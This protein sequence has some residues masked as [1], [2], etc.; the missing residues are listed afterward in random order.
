[1]A[2]RQRESFV[3]RHGYP[4]F[5]LDAKALLDRDV[6]QRDLQ[7]LVSLVNFGSDP[8][9]YIAPATA[10]LWK[11]MDEIPAALGVDA[12]TFAC[13]FVPAAGCSYTPEVIGPLV[14]WHVWRARLYDWAVSTT[15]GPGKTP[16]NPAL[17]QI[18]DD[19][20]ELLEEMD[21]FVRDRLR[22]WM[23]GKASE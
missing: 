15:T 20:I 19:L 6:V 23:T 21:E 2:T 17:T 8:A 14:R 12:A 22:F 5:A 13:G 10:A 11:L 1:M 4:R 18:G 7:S 9:T 16:D 3:R